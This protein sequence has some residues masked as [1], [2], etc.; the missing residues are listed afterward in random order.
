MKMNFRGSIFT[1][2]N[3][4]LLLLTVLLS[5]LLFILA[6]G[7]ASTRQSSSVR[8][9]EE[10]NYIR[11]EHLQDGRKQTDANRSN[12]VPMSC[13]KCKVVWVPIRSSWPSAYDRNDYGYYGHTSRGLGYRFP[14]W[15]RRHYCPGCKSV[16]TT[17]REGK[18][19]SVKVEHSCANCGDNSMLC[20][21]TTLGGSETPGMS[22]ATTTKTN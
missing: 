3:A 16:I 18:Q 9:V 7:C 15:E 14:Q 19:R 2:S 21:T 13:G 10:K 1:V 17:T 20:C 12:A 8:I 5:L 4:M 6:T 22:P 11:L